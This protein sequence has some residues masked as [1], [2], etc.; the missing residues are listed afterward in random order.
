MLALRHFGWSVY[1]LSRLYSC[2]RKSIEGW[3]N[4][5]HLNPIVVFTIERIALH[6]LPKPEEEHWKI[7]DG[8]KVAIG[9][10]YDE[11]LKSNGYP[12]RKK[13]EREYA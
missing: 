3:C 9:K 12:P 2:D 6:T 5:Y 4:H 8:E 1:S 7:L 10:T 11:Y 13:W